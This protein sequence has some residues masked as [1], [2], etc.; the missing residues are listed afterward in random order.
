MISIKGKER[1][2]L[3]QSLLVYQNVV[4]FVSIGGGDKAV[5]KVQRTGIFEFREADT[6]L[7]NSPFRCGTRNKKVPVPL[8]PDCPPG[9]GGPG[10]PRAPVGPETLVFL[11]INIE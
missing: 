1:D 5:F 8:P 4:L 3:L 10:S 11:T 9:P 6:I 7:D 2:E